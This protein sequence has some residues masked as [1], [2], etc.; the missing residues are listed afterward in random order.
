MVYPVLDSSYYICTQVLILLVTAVSQ[1]KA[2]NL[3]GVQH[4]SDF[5]L[6]SPTIFD[7][8]NWFGIPT[9][10]CAGT[11]APIPS[12]MALHEGVD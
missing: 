8:D 5:S 3:T 6:G 4:G 10:M 12:T 11:T 9:H 2:G 7:L 1:E